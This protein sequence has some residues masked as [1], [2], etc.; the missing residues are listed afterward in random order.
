M[1]PLRVA[2]I[3]VGHLGK[4]HARILAALPDVELI[5]V[6]DANA[7]QAHTVAARVG[8]RAYE[9]HAPLLEAVDAIVVAVPTTYH[10]AIA[11]ECLR[12]GVPVLVEKPLAADSKQADELVTLARRHGTLLQVGHIERFNPALEQLLQ[13][14]LQPRFIECLRLAGFTGRSADTGVTLDLMIHDLDL[15]LT[16]TNAAVLS[17]EAVGVSVFGRVEDVVNARVVFTNGCVANV[18][19]SRASFISQRCMHVWAPEGYVRVDF[20]K[21]RLLLVQPSEKVRRE[22]LNPSRLDAVTLAS[23]KDELFGRHLEM[24]ERDCSAGA[25]SLTR[26]LKHFV[27]CVRTGQEPRVPGEAGRDAI[28]LATQILECVS[29]HRWNG[30][31]DGPAGP[32]HIL[33]AHGN[34]FTPSSRSAAA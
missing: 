6:A 18:T 9:H 3:G 19:A 5:G 14:K 26:E 11:G 31:A 23:L 32:L 12:R 4:E 20:A 1:A 8:C 28:A 7:K 33:P 34:L 21:R 2:V 25:D 30:H 22:G 15:L 27:H 10:H 16:L 17:V 24:T 13:Y 29:Q